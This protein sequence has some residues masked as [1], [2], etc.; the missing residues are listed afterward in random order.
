MDI[1]RARLRYQLD[2]FG[3]R[4]FRERVVGLELAVFYGAEML[5][6]FVAGRALDAKG[7]IRN[8]ALKVLAQFAVVT[9]LGNLIA[10]RLEYAAGAAPQPAGF[11]GVEWLAPTA[12]FAFWGFSD[13]QVQTY[14]YWLIGA[15]YPRDAEA[16]CRLVGFYKLVQ[17]IG[18]C[19]G[20][21]LLP[22]ARCAFFT[23]LVLTAASFVVGTTL[24]L[25]VLPGDEGDGAA[26]LL[27]ANAETAGL[28]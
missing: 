18:W 3:D 24:A 25:R 26:P 2:G 20:F 28:A 11:Q 14:V 1:Q 6:G 4:F 19:V 16:R 15:L 5:G 27:D 10:G 23:Q 7:P 12:A 9:V 8:R 17:S 22:R 21:A 13:S